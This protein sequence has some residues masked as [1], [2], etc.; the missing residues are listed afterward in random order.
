MQHSLELLGKISIISL[1]YISI[2]H[3]KGR[4]ERESGK[5]EVGLG[6]VVV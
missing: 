4:R 3:L 6:E 5:E 2:T 1:E